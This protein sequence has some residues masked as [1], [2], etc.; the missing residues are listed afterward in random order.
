MTADGRVITATNIMTP[1]DADTFT[2][3]AV[4]RTL[5][6]EALADL[7]PIKVTRVKGKE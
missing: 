3:Q 1:I 5:D 2:W 7:P 4:E 6:G